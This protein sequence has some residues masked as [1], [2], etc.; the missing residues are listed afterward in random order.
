VRGLQWKPCGC[1]TWRTAFRT[2]RGPIYL[3]LSVTVRSARREPDADAAE[4]VK[5]IEA[6]INHDVKA[7]EYYVRDQLARQARARPPSSWSTSAVHRRTQ[8]PQLR[9]DVARSARRAVQDAGRSN[10]RAAAVRSALRR[11]GN[12]RANSRT[13]AS[14]TTLGKEFANVVARL[15]RARQRW[16]QSHPGEMEWRGRQ[17][18]RTCGSR[19]RR[20]LA[21][22]SRSFVES[23]GCIQLLHT[24]IEPHDWIAEYCDAVA[25]ANVVLIDLSRDVWAYIHSATC[26]SARRRRGGSSTMPTR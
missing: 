26:A 9:R 10:Q 7:V 12:A 24:Q 4:A 16:E 14:P 19:A 21:A 18:Q 22:I 1:C 11:Y 13:T 2:L 17:F 23:L 3:L 15:R 6:R 20:G 25:A 8:Q 5:V